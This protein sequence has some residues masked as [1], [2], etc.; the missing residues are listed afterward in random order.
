MGCD[1]D[2]VGLAPV[3]DLQGLCEPT[4]DAEVDPGV[5]YELLFDR[6]TEGPLGRPL[7]PRGDGDGDVPGE[8]PVARRVLGPKRVL[9]E[10][11]PVL[12]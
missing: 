7:L 5:V 8:G 2:V 12:L 1:V 11:W 10:E 4:G 3:G 6:L 9:D